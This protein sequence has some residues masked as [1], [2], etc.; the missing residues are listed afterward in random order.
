MVIGLTALTAALVLVHGGRIL[1]FGFPLMATVVAAVLFSMR[2]SV[3]CA[4]VWWTWL[5]TPL[6]RR[7]VDYQSGYHNVSP[8]MVTPLLVTGF[9]L[10]ALLRQP[11]FLLRR[12]ML[13]FFLLL[14]VYLNALLVG[15]FTNGP[16]PAMYEFSNWLVPTA[17]GAFL[18]MSPEGYAEIRSALVFAVLFGLLL[19]SLY[20]LYQFYN[21][22]PWDAYW[23]SES[24][25]TAAG[26]GL[27]EQTRLFSTLNSPGPFAIILMA[28]LVFTMVASGF[29]RFFAGGFG[30]PAFGL[31]LVRSAW[32]GWVIAAAFV[33]WRIGGKARV[34]IVVAA[35]VFAIIAV[36][37]TTAGPV[38]DVLSKRFASF[39]D[40]Q[41]DVSYQSRQGLYKSQTT[42]ALTQPIGVGFG[43]FGLASKLSTGTATV[44]DSGVLLI[45][46]ELGW[47]GGAFFLWAIGALLLRVLNATRG[48]SDRVAIAGAGVFIS[49]LIQNVF[50]L[51][52]SGGLALTLW[53]GLGL[54]LGQEKVLRA[55]SPTK[56]TQIFLPIG[57]PV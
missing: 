2:P 52:F 29:L 4:F 17:F 40:L 48:T 16:V 1:N 32:G 6:V 23:I 47:V 21:M 54:A 35:M 50:S 11:R 37:L 53:M 41:N 20:G 19:I 42:T 7:L 13:P 49:M 30:F 45:P 18:L 10:V 12:S 38:S 3:Y 57:R 24:G 43:Q 14:L 56:A 15:V 44:V 46:F 27:A 34:R 31:T 39:S 8:V 22:P 5:F 28:S 51:Q 55:A 9:T 36:P 26:S 33:I 25:Y